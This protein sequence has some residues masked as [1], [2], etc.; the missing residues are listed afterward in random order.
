MN[1]LLSE[2]MSLQ[3]IEQVNQALD[4][5]NIAQRNI[6]A[7]AKL[8][9]R[10]GDQVQFK[11]SKSGETIKGKVTAINR[12]NIVIEEHQDEDHGITRRW[13]VSPSL[14]EKI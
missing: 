7:R 9:Y 4:A 12:K 8:Q 10:V 5:L 14:L 11:N 6:Q 3:D 2:L 13:T 1:A